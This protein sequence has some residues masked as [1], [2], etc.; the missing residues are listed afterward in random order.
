MKRYIVFI[1][2]LWSSFIVRANE[3]NIVCPKEELMLEEKTVCDIVIN[4]DVSVSS[5]SFNYDS[6][7]LQKCF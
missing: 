3:L 1:L 7:F 4:L 2:F 6:D 5:V